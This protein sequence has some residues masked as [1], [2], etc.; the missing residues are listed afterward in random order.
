MSV[1]FDPA[2]PFDAL[3]ELPG[4]FDFDSPRI[5][6]KALAASHALA[7]ANAA[8]AKLPDPSLFYAP[9]LVRESL[10]SSAVE[11]IRTTMFEALMADAVPEKA[12]GPQ[13]EVLNYKSA[14]AYGLEKVRERGFVHTGLLEEIQEIVEPG[15]G[16]IRRMPVCLR[17]GAGETVYTPPVGEERIRRLLMNLDSFVNASDDG[18]DPLV[19]IGAAHYQFEAIHPFLDGNGRV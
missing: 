14:L 3:P 7:K 6:K 5:L 17:N 9:F 16:G 2:V 10:E 19:K 1:R 13:K 4:G 11:N 15:K 12:E 18:F 8:A